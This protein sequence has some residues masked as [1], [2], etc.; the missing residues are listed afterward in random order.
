[1]SSFSPLS[2]AL[3]PCNARAS[4]GERGGGCVT[5]LPFAQQWL[6]FLAPLSP[7]HEVG[8]LGGKEGE[9]RAGIGGWG[10]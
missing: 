7:S 8:L 1:M 4:L 2:L 5:H 3:S 6:G 10:L 9:E